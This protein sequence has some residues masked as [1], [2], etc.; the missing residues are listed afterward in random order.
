MTSGPGRTEFVA[1]MAML[2]ATVAFSIDAMLPALPRIGAALSPDDVNRAQLVVT[3]FVLG[4]GA[5][6]LFAGPLSDAFGRKRV[7]LAGAAIYSIAAAVAGLA[8]SLE[9]LLAARVVQGIGAAGPRIAAQAVIRDLYAGR[10]MARI[11]SFVMIVFT[12]V[13]VL[14]PALGAAIII[15]AGWRAVF[16]AFV[17]FAALSALWL[18]TRLPETLPPERRRPVRLGP[19][20]AAMAEMLAIPKVR[21]A[22]AAQTLSFGMLFAM[23]SSTQQVFDITFGRGDSFPYWFGGIALVA[24]SSGVLNAALVVRLGMAVLVFAMFRAQIAFSVLMIVAL[25]AGLSNDVLFAIFVV[26]QTT[27]FFQAGMTIGNTASITLEPVGHIAG[28]ASSVA[29]S[30]ATVLAVM[31]AA[32]VGLM[33]DGTP[34][35]LAFGI[36]IYSGLAALLAW[37]LVHLDRIG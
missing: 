20:T 27:V 15:L 1:L 32:P 10:E 26:W 3:S 25:L 33:F 21:L 12:I 22:I 6:T 9:V 23:L 13:P 37:R 2:A 30:V 7:M 19:L 8:Q 16:A 29:G 11:L 35:P 5:G 14:A 18:A 31:L 4:M 34:L 17:V 28:L 36:L 24:A